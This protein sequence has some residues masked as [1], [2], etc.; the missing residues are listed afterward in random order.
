MEVSEIEPKEMVDRAFIAWSATSR[1]TSR[2]T[3]GES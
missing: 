2:K 3:K 1:R